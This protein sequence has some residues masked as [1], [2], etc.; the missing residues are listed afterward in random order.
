[1]SYSELF[2]ILDRSGSMQG[3]HSDMEGAIVSILDKQKENQEKVLV[4]FAR[5]DNKYEEVFHEKDISDI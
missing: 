3:I 5:F 4:S 2:F 1:M